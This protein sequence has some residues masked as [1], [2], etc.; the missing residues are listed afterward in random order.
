M[1]LPLP[2]K[3]GSLQLFIKLLQLE[4]NE[5]LSYYNLAKQIIGEG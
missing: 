5:S 2:D 3:I 1:Q 4:I